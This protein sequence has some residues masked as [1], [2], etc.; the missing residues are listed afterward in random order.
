MWRETTQHERNRRMFHEE[1]DGFLPDAVFDFHVHLM[2]RGVIPGGKT[3]SCAGH[4]LTHYD[5]DDLLHDLPAVYPGRHTGAVCFGFPNVRYVHAANNAY[6]ARVCDRERF[7]PFRLIDPHEPDHAA[8]RDDIV[9]N[10]F[11]GV[12][13]Y[14]GYARTKDINDVEIHDMLP[15]WVMEI[16]NDMGLIVMLHIPRKQRLADPLNQRQIVELCTLYPRAK[17]VLAHVGRA[18]YL[19]N[20][21]GNLDRLKTLPNLY[22][23]LAMVS[24]WEVLEHVFATVPRGRILYGTDTPIAL[25]PGTSVEI[26]DQ[27]T[28]VTPVPWEL[29][30]HDVHHKLVF[31]SF[32]YEGL[33][34]IR[35]AVTRLSL[36]DRFVR[37][38]FYENAISLLTTAP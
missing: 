36:D 35:K 5:M 4:A 13:P 30:I 20:V 25:A 1:F 11:S 12:K 32:L 16:A 6:V 17:I 18:Y 28:Y 27:Y 37:D 31:T 23:D 3:Y 34:A 10:R 22:Y 7:F 14:P 38:V 2:N 8:V 15:P 29:S 33:R 21:L 26:N 19:K 24:N 9:R